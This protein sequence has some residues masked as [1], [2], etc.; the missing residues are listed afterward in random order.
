MALILFDFDGVLADTL[1]D[2]LQFGQEVCNELGVAHIVVREDLSTLE[3]MSFATFGRQLEVHEALID[4]FVR[5]CLEKV[6]AKE[7]PPEIFAGLAEVVRELS[8]RHVLGIVTT[9]T[10]Q[11]VKAFLAQNKLEDCIRAIYGLEQPGTKAEKISMARNQFTA[12]GEAVYM[13]G[14]AV[15][16]IH[17]AK[18]ASVKSIAVSWG[19]QS[20]DRL[21]NAGADHVVHSAGELLAFF[22]AAI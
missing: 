5:R 18:Q 15:S 9:N 21:S 20:L 3:V 7:S 4:E 19:H 11:N 10:S 14:D 17:A 13:I 8:T 22:E 6:A 12:A 16:D 2:L 1:N